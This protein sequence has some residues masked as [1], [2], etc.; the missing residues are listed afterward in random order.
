MKTIG[1]IVIAMVALLALTGSVMA[2]G[3]VN[4]TPEIQGITV[5]T[6]VNA[7]GTTSQTDSLT[8][9]ITNVGDLTPPLDDMQVLYTTTYDDKL[10]AVSGQ[11]TWKKE[12][13]ISTA[14]QVGSQQNVKMDANLQYEADGTGRA[15]REENIDL[16]GEATERLTDTVY[17]CPFAVGTSVYVP[18][19]CN[20]V[21][22]GSKIDATLTSVVTQA[23]ESFVGTNSDFPVTQGYSIAAK[24][25]TYSDGTIPMLGSASSWQTVAIKEARNG[26]D[27]LVETLGWKHTASAGNV[28]NS[29]N[30]VMNYQSGFILA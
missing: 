23:K 7:L 24:G 29:Y 8:W 30:D 27:T 28:I 9:I 3:R 17:M 20:R 14:N 12:A 6:S 1:V 2:D 18:T 21:L 25:I 16:S 5:S 11:T 10:S 15:I 19:Y 13:V 26:S 22:S 4:A